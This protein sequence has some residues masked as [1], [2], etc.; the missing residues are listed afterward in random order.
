[1][2]QTLFRWGGQLSREIIDK[3]DIGKVLTGNFIF[4]FPGVQIS[5]QTLVLVSRRWWTGY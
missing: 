2:H 1:M 5:S 3:G 4:A